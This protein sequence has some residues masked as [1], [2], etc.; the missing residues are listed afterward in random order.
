MKN[1]DQAG[2]RG[3][4]LFS[5]APGQYL[6]TSRESSMNHK[7]KKALTFGDLIAAVYGTCGRRSAGGIIWL[8]IHARLITFRGRLCHGI[9]KYRILMM[10]RFGPAGGTAAGLRP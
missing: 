6:S 4:G 3:C 10:D 7:H 8:A 1:Q 2:R 9:S 5:C